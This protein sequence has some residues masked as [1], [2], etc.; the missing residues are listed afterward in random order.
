MTVNRIS[1]TSKRLRE[2]MA[3]RGLRQVDIVNK[4]QP[5]CRKYHIIINK[6]DI[7][8]WIKGTVEPSQG[9]LFV[10]C[11]AL[12]VSEPWMMG[13]DVPMERPPIASD[14]VIDDDGTRIIVEELRGLD[15]SERQL[16]A[17]YIAL[18]KRA[19]K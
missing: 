16:V 1:N 8:I 18:L 2:I 12:G 11:L 3:E 14:I 6:A 13:F 5:Y 19:K 7:S 10:L 15:G 17:D 4:C 9:K